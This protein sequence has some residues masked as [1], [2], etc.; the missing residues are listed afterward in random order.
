MD[1]RAT[2]GRRTTHGQGLLA[3]TFEHAVEFSRNVRALISASRP[4]SGQ[5]VQSMLVG[6]AVSNRWSD[7]LR[8]TQHPPAAFAAYLC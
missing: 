5:P 8:P 2:D 1:N 4:I 6:Y 3:L 7:L